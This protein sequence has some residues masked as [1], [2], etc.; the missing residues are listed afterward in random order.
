MHPTEKKQYRLIVLNFILTALI[1][2]GVIIAAGW[3]LML[4][5]RVNQ[6]SNTAGQ[7][8]IQLTLQSTLAAYQEEIAVEIREDVEP[9][10]ITAV[11]TEAPEVETTPAPT[12]TPRPNELTVSNFEEIQLILNP[13]LDELSDQRFF[14]LPPLSFSFPEGWGFRYNSTGTLTVIDSFGNETTMKIHA[15]NNRR[16]FY[17]N[18]IGAFTLLPDGTLCWY[19]DTTPRQGLG[20]GGYQLFFTIDD[21]TSEPIIITVEDPPMA[22]ILESI[23]M[24][25]TYTDII[26]DRRYLSFASQ[27]EPMS[28]YGYMVLEDGSIYIRVWRSHDKFYYWVK[29]NFVMHPDEGLLYNDLEDLLNPDGSEMI[30]EIDL[31]VN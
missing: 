6:L 29:G 20:A 15:S 11:E 22:R 5:Q 1:L 7:L 24:Y 3:L 4:D 10:P 31:T 16:E 30:P 12:A 14:R 8:A 27:Q 18:E 25:R 19:P 28:M 17:L 21:Y 13:G 2:L 9:Q 23:P 26:E